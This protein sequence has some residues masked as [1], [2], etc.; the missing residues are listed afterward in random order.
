MTRAARRPASERKAAI[1]GAIALN[2]PLEFLR[3]LWAVDHAL[4]SASKHMARRIGVTG[5]QR[6]VLRLVGRRPGLSPG[7]L[8]GVLHVDPSTL[9]GI[10]KRL[11]SRGLIE[12]SPDPAD[13]R[14]SRIRLT[15]KGRERDARMQGTVEAIVRRVLADLPA[16]DVA[17]AGRVLTRLADSLGE[18]AG[19]RSAKPALGGGNRKRAVRRR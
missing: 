7:D 12:L 5:P 2:E 14:R 16:R 10:L 18:L 19:D 13:G 4:Q 9:T 3:L 15:A 17:A 8:A 1:V 6:L 11:G